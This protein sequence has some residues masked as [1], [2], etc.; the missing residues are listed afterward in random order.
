MPK[1]PEIKLPVKEET[2]GLKEKG[3]TSKMSL[4][5]HKDDRKSEP[6]LE[7]M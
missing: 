6:V 2:Q 5:G 1:V 3:E 7:G 4:E